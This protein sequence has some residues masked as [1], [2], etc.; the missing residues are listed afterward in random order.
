LAGSCRRLLANGPQLPIDFAA[1]AAPRLKFLRLRH[2]LSRLPEFFE[3]AERLAA[4]RMVK[5]FK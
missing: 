2:S 3:I 1:V 5:I 4:S